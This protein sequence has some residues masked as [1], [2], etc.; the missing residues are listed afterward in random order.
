MK[1]LHLAMHQSLI[2]R[3]SLKESPVVAL[4]QFDSGVKLLTS[5]PLTAKLAL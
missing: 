3:S 4:Q 2:T 5:I 1:Y